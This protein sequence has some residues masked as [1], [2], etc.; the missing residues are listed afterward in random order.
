MK[1][2]VFFI[3]SIFFLPSCAPEYED[4]L[5]VV[6][7]LYSISIPGFMKET[8]ELHEEASLQ[9]G[10][11]LKHFYVAVLD[12]T[13]SEIYEVYGDSISLDTMQYSFDDL[14]ELI[15]VT[16]TSN[17]EKIETHEIVDTIINEMS[18]KILSFS[19]NVQGF[20]A[21]FTIGVYESL[22]RFYQ[23]MVWTSGRNREKYKLL[24]KDIHYSF[25][26]I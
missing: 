3:V 1:Y 8:D 21:F 9:Y 14:K 7:D 11:D 23:V 17:F 22:D 6:N 24:M 2:L 15:Q 18:A 25:K 13:K 16:F 12:E 4:Q 10:N 19:G 5:I 26:E 20:N